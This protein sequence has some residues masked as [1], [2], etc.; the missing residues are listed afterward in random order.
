LVA[1]ARTCQRTN[2][3]F[4]ARSSQRQGSAVEPKLPLDVGRRSPRKRPSP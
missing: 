1:A 4:R 3:G 2:D